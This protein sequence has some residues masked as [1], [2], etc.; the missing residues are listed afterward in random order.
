MAH[1]IEKAGTGKLFVIFAWHCFFFSLS[2]FPHLFSL[3][4]PF[5]SCSELVWNEVRCVW[6]ENQKKKHQENIRK[7]T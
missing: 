7:R 1:V 2:H 6:E 4:S 3:V 5:T